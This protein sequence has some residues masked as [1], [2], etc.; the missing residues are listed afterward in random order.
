M[1]EVIPLTG[2]IGAH[3]PEVVT[4]A[5][6]CA[7][8]LYEVRKLLTVIDDRTRRGWSKTPYYALHRLRVL[9]GVPVPTEEESER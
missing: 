7:E 8:L 2:D 5:S 3:L 6:G 9:A 1:G 4:S